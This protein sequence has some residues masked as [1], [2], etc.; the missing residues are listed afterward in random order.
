[1]IIHEKERVMSKMFKYLRGYEWQSLLAPLFKLLE[2]FFDLLVPL[3]VA[4]IINRGVADADFVYVAEQFVILL[5]LAAVG[6]SCSITA[7][8]FAARASVGF[9]TRLRQSLFDHIQKFSFADLDAVGTDTL[10]T[11]LTSDI[12]QIQNGLNLA[13][14]LLLRSPFIVF[15]AMIM[16]FTINVKAALIFAGVIP[17]LCV[18]VFSIMLISIPMFKKVQRRLDL[19]LSS[20]R[21]NL[22][23]VRVIRAFRREQDEVREFDERN[24][25]LTS[26]NEKVGLV[27]AFMNPLTYAIINIATVLLIQTGAVQVSM[28]NIAQGDV[29]ALYNYMAQIVVELIKMATL[30]ITIDKS[31]ACAGRVN[32]VLE[33]NP[34]MKYGSE[35]ADSQAEKAIDFSHVSFTYAGASESSVEDVS[36]SLPAGKTLGIIG[37]TGSG[38]STLAGLISRSYDA[39]KGEIRLFG[40]NIMNCSEAEIHRLVGIV[41]QRAVLFAGTVRDNMR[42]GNKNA[43]DEQIWQA[44]ETAQAADVIR[45][46]KG[47]LDFVIEQNGRNLSGGQKQRLTIARALTADPQILLLDDSASALD[48]ATDAALRRALSR[49]RKTTVIISQ[50]VSSIRH[51]DMILVLDDGVPAGIGTH[52]ELMENCSVY[53]EIC[54]SQF[55]QGMPSEMKKEVCHA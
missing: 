16:A 4:N 15:G 52:E 49:L 8:Y 30:I 40:K 28:G 35:T 2:A 47:G 46:K 11:R 9:A 41:P 5:V 21:E 22:T 36:F 42:L 17:V 55:P 53:Q 7:Q 29:V 18:V 38:K 23:G 54:H 27:S 37:G 39:D 48:F 26:L 6:L 19:V 51:A 45:E 31:L 13:L 34:T 32:Q 12:N 25:A 3:F 14:R 20:T 24:R 1:M 33:I 43:T 44:L 10:I 50:R